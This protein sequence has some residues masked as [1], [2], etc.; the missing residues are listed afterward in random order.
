M[1]TKSNPSSRW[2]NGV[3]EFVENHNFKYKGS[4]DAGRDFRQEDHCCDFCGT[5]LR[6]TAVIETKSGESI[7]KEVGLDCLEHTF[8]TKWSR[9]Q[10]VE[11]DIKDLKQKAKM[12]RRKEKFQEEYGNLI[13]WMGRYLNIKENSFLRSM[14]NVLTTGSDKF[15]RKMEEAVKE[16]YDE[17][18]LEDL[19]EKEKKRKE[20]K[21]RYQQKIDKLKELIIKIDDLDTNKNH[22]VKEEHSDLDFLK[23]L[24][25]FLKNQGYLTDRQLKSLNNIFSRYKENK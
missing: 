10:D 22:E 1:S 19:R 5:H 20:R 17:T 23:S 25:D 14:Y 7:E 18:D 9:L 15:T 24:E 11:R 4:Y 8:G 21:I 12:E 6:Y 16:I 3:V 2:K 13:D